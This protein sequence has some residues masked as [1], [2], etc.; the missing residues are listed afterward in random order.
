M[1]AKGRNV[2]SCSIYFFHINALK[3]G[4]TGGGQEE[5]LYLSSYWR[6]GAESAYEDG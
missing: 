3:L 5:F 4:G 2:S 6:L 1:G